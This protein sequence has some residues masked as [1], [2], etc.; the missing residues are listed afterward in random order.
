LAQMPEEV[1]ETLKLGEEGLIQV[2]MCYNDNGECE[3]WEC[4]SSAHE[5]RFVPP[6]ELY[7]ARS[8]SEVEAIYR[9][10]RP[11]DTPASTSD[12]D[13]GGYWRDDEGT[14]FRESPITRLVRHTRDYPKCEEFDEAIDQHPEIDDATRDKLQDI[15]WDNDIPGASNM[16]IG[17]Y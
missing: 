14:P 2:Y 15:S 12:S 4:F 3:S 10:L 13:S 11:K 1:Q 17:M 6:E 7:S 9:E 5:V 16:Y 8:R